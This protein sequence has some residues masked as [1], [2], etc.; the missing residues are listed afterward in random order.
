[1]STGL[2]QGSWLVYPGGLWCCISQTIEFEIRVIQCFNHL[3]VQTQWPTAGK[4]YFSIHQGR[5][6]VL[7][8]WASN[9]CLNY[10]KFTL[11]KSKSASG[12]GFLT[13]VEL[14]GR[15]LAESVIDSSI[16]TAVPTHP[17]IPSPPSQP[18]VM[19]IVIIRD[20]DL[21][22]DPVVLEKEVVI[23]WFLLHASS[24]V[25]TREFAL[26]KVCTENE[27]RRAESERIILSGEQSLN[28]LRQ[29]YKPTISQNHKLTQCLHL[30]D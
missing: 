13:K 12:F 21:K 14:S 29:L 5:K 19:D 28:Q 6:P 22:D 27:A 11:V 15:I 24:E 7:K 26:Q 17:S 10:N 4:V 23:D 25:W 2:H 20:R 9:L 30:G 3:K 8:N 1:M 16:A 18:G